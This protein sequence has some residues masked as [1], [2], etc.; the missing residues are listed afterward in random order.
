[1]SEKDL[2]K[3][4]SEELVEALIADNSLASE[5]NN[6]GLWEKIYPYNWTILLSLKPEYSEHCN[7]WND[8]SFDNLLT[9]L[10]PYPQFFDKYDKWDNLSSTNWSR[11]LASL[12]QF[13]DKCNS[14]NKFDP[15]DWSRLLANQPQFANRC[16]YWKDFTSSQW[17][18]ILK[19]QLQFIKKAKTCGKKGWLAILQTHPEYSEKYKHWDK[20]SAKDWLKLLSIRPRYADK[21]T[22]WHLFKTANWERLLSKHPQFADKCEI[23]HKFKR[24]TIAELVHKNPQ[25]WVYSPK[26]SLKRIKKNHAEGKQCKCWDR[27]APSD[28]FDLLIKHPQFADKCPGITYDTFSQS[29]W[30]ELEAKHPEIFKEQHMLSTL[31]KIAK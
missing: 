27:I 12:P 9:L 24:Q 5:F 4:S 10:I 22:K 28:F 18:N 11:L 20:F 25:L 1:M 8:F 17:A 16:P 6:L 19:S 3:M 26:E 21:C 2:T 14:W 7:K 30:N 31:R 23:W 29:Q 15:T 13:A